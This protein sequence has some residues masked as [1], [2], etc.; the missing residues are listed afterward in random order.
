MSNRL[1]STL[2]SGARVLGGS[3]IRI[4]LALLA[5][6]TVLSWAGTLSAPVILSYPLLLVALSPRLTFLGLAAAATSLPVFV[7]I[8]GI[9][10]LLADPINF[11]LGRR[12]APALSL[13]HI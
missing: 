11:D 2:R 5:V 9:R 4:H 13:I 12:S 3:R 10:L 6:L 8:G 7:L 1:V